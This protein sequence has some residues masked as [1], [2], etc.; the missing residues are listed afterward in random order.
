MDHNYFFNWFNIGTLLHKTRGIVFRFT[1]FGESSI[2]VSIFT[3]L[4]GLQSYIVNGV[5]SKSV[6]SRIALYQPLTLL[7]LVVYYR[8]TAAIKRIKEIKCIHPYQTLQSDVRKAALAMFI[9]EVI[10]RAVKEETHTQ[11]ICEFLIS[12]LITLDTMTQA[13]ENFHL[14][15][16]LKLSRYLGFGA[17]QVIELLGGRITDPLIEQV[18]LKLIQCEY[19]SNL[20]ITN[21]QRREILTLLVAFY[22]EHSGLLGEMKSIQVLKEILM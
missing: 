10:N 7:E 16:L 21:D 13:V 3:E 20:I 17:Q 15:F 4:F 6:K 2:I 18:L 19:Q 22:N 8:D 9:N 14:I 12:S 1:R 11:E 5:R